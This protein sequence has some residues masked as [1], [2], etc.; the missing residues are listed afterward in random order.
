MCKDLS[1]HAS[2]RELNDV[3]LRWIFLRLWGGNQPAILLME[4]V[5]QMLSIL[6]KKGVGIN[7]HDVSLVIAIIR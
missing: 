1:L 3:V 2:L 7:E 5:P 6:E 4:I